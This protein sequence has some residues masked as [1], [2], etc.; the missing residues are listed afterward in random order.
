MEYE[1][2]K[3]E[4]FDKWLRKLKDRQAAVAIIK[5]LGRAKLGNFGDVEPVGEGVSEMRIFTGPSYRLYYTIRQNAII[6]MLCGGDKS[7]QKKDIKKA[8]DLAKQ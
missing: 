3:T 4:I 2:E 8:K 5:R 7:S 1:I 6:F